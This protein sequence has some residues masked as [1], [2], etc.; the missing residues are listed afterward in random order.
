LSPRIPFAGENNTERGRLKSR[1]QN[2]SPPA[3]IIL[4]LRILFAEDS[5]ADGENRTGFSRKLSYNKSIVHNVI[6]SLAMNPSD[7]ITLKAFVTALNQLDEP[8]PPNIQKHLN[9][10]GK[11]IENSPN[12]IAYLEAV[13]PQYP[14]LNTAYLKARIPLQADANERNKGKTDPM[15][16]LPDETS[17]ELTN[18][19]IAIFQAS[20][21]VEAAKVAIA[22]DNKGGFQRLVAFFKKSPGN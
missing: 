14:S 11:Q 8:L 16:P 2:L 20:N 17:H 18:R 13:A 4:S 1:L 9:E 12:A 19:A 10:V 7:E 21:S 5:F 6:A 22:Q 15:P 3:R